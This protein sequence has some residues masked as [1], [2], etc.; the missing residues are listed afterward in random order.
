[1]FFDL[2]LLV[3]LAIFLSVQLGVATC[4]S[5]IAMSCCPN[6]SYYV[7]PWSWV[8]SYKFT[9][10]SCT[11]DGVIFFTKTGKQFCVQ[12]GAKWVQRFISLVNTRNHL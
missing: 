2:G 11:S 3:L 4:G 7:I 5:S 1:M 8:Y 9:D 6:F 10:K 12:P